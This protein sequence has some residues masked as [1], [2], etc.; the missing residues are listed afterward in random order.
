MLHPQ[1]LAC[2]PRTHPPGAG[3]SALR[4]PESHPGFASVLC[5]TE[6]GPSARPVPGP[7]KSPSPG[8]APLFGMWSKPPE[9]SCASRRAPRTG[10]DA[11]GL[12][13]QARQACGRRTEP[14]S[15]PVPTAPAAAGSAG[16]AASTD[17]TTLKQSQRLR[18]GARV[19][20]P[21]KNGRTQSPGCG[22]RLGDGAEPPR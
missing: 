6:R 19:Q 21:R 8:R 20:K 15:P 12:S 10:S 13:L 5:D 14:T 7:L 4:C 11:A 22:E 17:G 2:A 16:S 3:C 1:V 18:H 9:S